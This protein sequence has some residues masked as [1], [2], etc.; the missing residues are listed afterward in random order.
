MANKKEIINDLG[1][2]RGGLGILGIWF[3]MI[4]ERMPPQEAEELAYG[5]RTGHNISLVFGASLDGR[6]RPASCPVG[7]ITQATSDW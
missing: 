4:L 2:L 1:D 6:T 7:R 3:E 5:Y